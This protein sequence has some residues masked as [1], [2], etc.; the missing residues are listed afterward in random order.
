MTPLATK[1]VLVKKRSLTHKE[2]LEDANVQQ[3]LEK[4]SVTEMQRAMGKYYN[5]MKCE[6]KVVEALESSGTDD[7]SKT[8]LKKLRPNEALASIK[9]GVRLKLRDV[10]RDEEKAREANQYNNKVHAPVVIKRTDPNSLLLQKITPQN[11]FIQRHK[12]KMNLLQQL[13]KYQKGFEV[14]HKPISEAEQKAMLNSTKQL[15]FDKLSEQRA[16]RNVGTC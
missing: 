9:A 10:I 1:S 11:E 8:A 7:E 4:E 13:T 14:A 12:N 6:I 2:F 3:T 16:T 15:F 5:R